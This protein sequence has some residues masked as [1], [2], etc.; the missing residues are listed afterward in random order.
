MII[1][2]ICLITLKLFN[3]IMKKDR[4]NDKYSNNNK[5]L[6][7]FSISQKPIRAHYLTFGIKK[8]FS[9]LKNAYI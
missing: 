8:I 9:H 5:N 4:V 6:S 3:D 2:T 1:F 7:T